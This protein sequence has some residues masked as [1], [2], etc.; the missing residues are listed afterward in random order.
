VSLNVDNNLYSAPAVVT[1]STAAV[2]DSRDFPLDIAGWPSLETENPDFADQPRGNEADDGAYLND[3]FTPTTGQP[4]LSD[5]LLPDF[6]PAVVTANFVD[7]E[8]VTSKTRQW[9][10]VHDPVRSLRWDGHRLNVRSPMST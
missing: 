3:D 4:P 7:N 10:L 1:P 9:T 2:Q 5:S 6:Q 8:F